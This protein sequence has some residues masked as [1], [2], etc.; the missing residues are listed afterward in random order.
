MEIFVK[1]ISGINLVKFSWVIKMVQEISD[2][3]LPNYPSH[4]GG[5]LLRQV[6]CYK[7]KTVSDPLKRI[8]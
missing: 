8:Y 1:I 5:N 6:T 3:G 2:A 7:V 4:S